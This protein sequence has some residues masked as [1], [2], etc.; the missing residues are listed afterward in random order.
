MFHV[1]KDDV[2]QHAQ[3]FRVRER[4]VDDQASGTILKRQSDRFSNFSYM[5]ASGYEIRERQ[6]SKWGRSVVIDFQMVSTH[7]SRYV[8]RPP[9]EAK[10][11]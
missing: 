5:L 7:T 2:T 4:V 9:E 11:P 1:H 10:I 3:N 6:W 8:T